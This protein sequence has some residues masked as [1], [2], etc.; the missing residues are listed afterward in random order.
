MCSVS[1]SSYK[2]T[3]AETPARWQGFFQFQMVARGEIDL[4]LRML[5]P[6]L[7][8]RLLMVQKNLFFD[9]STERHRFLH[10]QPHRQL[11]MGIWLMAKF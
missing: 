11:E 9:E 10:S 2:P 7:G 4:S 3:K 8:S 5:D 1:T 6:N